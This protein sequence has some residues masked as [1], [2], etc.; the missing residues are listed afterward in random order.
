MNNSLSGQA[1]IAVVAEALAIR[2]R[3]M[4]RGFEAIFCPLTGGTWWGKMGP[5][6]VIRGNRLL[7][8]VQDWLNATGQKPNQNPERD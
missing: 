4:G 3:L 8:A 7:V 1:R 6:G 2:A 5:M